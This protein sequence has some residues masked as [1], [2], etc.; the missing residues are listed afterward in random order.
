MA[1]DSHT[2]TSGIFLFGPFRLS[3]GGRRLEKDG[4]P[5]TIG[6]RAFDVLVVL[7]E[8]AGRVV[9]KRD[10]LARVWADVI[11]DE[12]SLRFHVSELRKVL[13]DG[14]SEESYVSNVPGR[15]YCFVA[16]VSRE[17]APAPQKPK[18]PTTY[19]FSLGGWWGGKR[20][21]TPY[22]PNWR[23]GGS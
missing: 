16:P 2:E 13:G 8:N 20:R 22:A 1:T 14:Q 6:G 18:N 12:G 17:A 21:F 4:R 23:I 5:L 11:V 15:G 7:L 3:M 10:L 19:L 9:S